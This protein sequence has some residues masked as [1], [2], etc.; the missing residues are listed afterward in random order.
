[1]PGTALYKRLRA[2]GRLLLSSSGNNTDG[3]LNFIP[4]METQ[5]LIEGYHRLLEQIYSPRV[6]YERLWNFIKDYQPQVKRPLHREDIFAF[7]KSIWHLG[8]V[9]DRKSK[10]YYWKIL[11]KS[12]LLKRKAF[13]QAIVLTIFGY[14]FRKLVENREGENYCQAPSTPASN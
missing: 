11:F 4:K 6:Y 8:I 14:H 13:S 1:M 9:G 7:L 12:L 5:T 3:S 2:E 10:R